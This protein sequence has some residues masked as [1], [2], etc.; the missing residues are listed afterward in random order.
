[1]W[2][3][4][5]PNFNMGFSP[6]MMSSMMPF[7]SNFFGYQ[8]MN[9]FC[10]FSPSIFN[11]TPQYSTP[12]YNNIFGLFG[13]PSFNFSFN[14][15]SNETLS[16]SKSNDGLGAV[17]LRNAKGYVGQVNSDAEGNRLFS[18]GGRAQGWCQDFVSCMFKKSDANVPDIFKK[19]SSPI[20]ARDEAIKRGA[21]VRNPKANDLHA[22]DILVTEGK[23]PSGL[24]VGIVDKVENGKIYTVSGNSGNSVR[25]SSYA[26]NS[27]KVYGVIQTDKL[28]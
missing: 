3:Y 8:P 22:G 21:Y 24:H 17:I 5:W 10:N 23:G 18:P 11:F 9:L 2:N 15:T 1:M 20:V 25:E 4:F 6:F 28:A 14:N 27:S 12:Q 13:Q 19:T 7:G 26:L 16:K